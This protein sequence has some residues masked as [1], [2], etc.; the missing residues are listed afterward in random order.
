MLIFV[1]DPV[2]SVRAAPNCT[3]N[4]TKMSQINVIIFWNIA[5]C[6]QH[7]TRRF[8]GTY[9]LHLQDPKQSN[10]KPVCRLAPC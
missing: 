8:G 6:I 2:F 5:Q 10:K 3:G 9:H 7:M 4:K 1:G